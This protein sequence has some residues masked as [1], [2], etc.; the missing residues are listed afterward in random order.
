MNFTISKVYEHVYCIKEIS[1]KEHCNCYLIIG[2]TKAV[3][4]DLGI[5]LID[6]SSLFSQLDITVPIVAVLTHFHFDHFGGH[7]QF[8]IIF[9]NTHNIG[10]NDTGLAYF[11]KRDFTNSSQFELVKNNFTI[12]E[13]KFTHL[14]NHSNIDLGNISLKVI[15]TPGHDSSSICLWDEHN[16]ILFSGDLIYPGTLLYNFNDSN[17]SDYVHSL[18]SIH[19]LNPLMIF[20][21]HNKPII[22]N[23]SLF[24]TDS[25]NKLETL[26]KTC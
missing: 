14:E 23:V 18:K 15:N 1:Y 2:D 20:G 9:A 19:D 22:D 13:S 16:K 21:G 7:N 8:E 26:I 6:F 10:M 5:G 25:I 24:I 17:I 4:L 12:I 11:H 3:L